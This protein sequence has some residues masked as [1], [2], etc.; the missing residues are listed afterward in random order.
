MRTL[1]EIEADARD[2]RPFA[3]GTEGYGWMGNW[4]YRP[5][6]HD[7]PF[8]NDISPRGCPIILVAF[9]GKTPAEFL[10][11]PRDEQGLYSIED[12]YHCIEFR[13]PGSGGGEPRRKPTP[14]GQGELFPRTGVE[15]P[16]MFVQRQEAGVH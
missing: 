7:L 5:C 12:Q 10:D 11:G 8:Q 9:L 1:A 13:A 2:Q 14:S 16:R 4:C 15:G 6:L 3:N